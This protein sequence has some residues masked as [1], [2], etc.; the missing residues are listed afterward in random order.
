MSQDV[1][2]LSAYIK[3]M[4]T[5]QELFLEYFDKDDEKH[6]INLKNY[7]DENK[8]SENKQD[9]ITTLCF[10]SKFS[11]NHHRSSNFYNKI[12]KI[13]LYFRPIFSKYCTNIDIF[14]IFKKT[15][16][17]LLILFNEQI[18][19]PSP[20]IYAISVTD[21]YKNMNYMQYFQKEFRALNSEQL[22]APDDYEEKRAKGENDNLLC[23]LIRNDDINEFIK[24]TGR[25]NVSLSSKVES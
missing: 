14:N 20:E 3:Q 15:K 13:L 24:C 12:Q 1:K 11:K 23:S 18:L 16:L 9:F 17:L 5:Y 10:I 2:E 21:S 7:F 6:F 19:I 4:R 8:I 22:N 25:L